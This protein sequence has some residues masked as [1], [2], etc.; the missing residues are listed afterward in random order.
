MPNL[1]ILFNPF[2]MLTEL[3][4]YAA[5]SFFPAIF[6]EGGTA[7]G[8]SS[9]VTVT[10]GTGTPVQPQSN[11]PNVNPSVSGG[12]YN[13]TP[14][15]VEGM[16][17]S[18]KGKIYLHWTAGDGGTAY[19]NRYH[20]TILADGKVQEVLTRSLIH[21]GDTLHIEIVKVLDFQ[22]QQWQDGTGL[23]LNQRNLMH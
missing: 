13:T 19:P 18:K 4:P 8:G 11:Q 16:E 14:A 7:F 21:L 12:G 15:N 5:K 3:I 1:S 23:Q 6:G 22:S 10:S 9:S 20:T 17:A 2:A